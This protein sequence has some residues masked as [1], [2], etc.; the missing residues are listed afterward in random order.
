[1]KSVIIDD[2]SR[3]ILAGGEFKDVDTENSKL[4]VDQLVERYWW[5]CPLRALLKRI[6][7]GEANL[8]PSMINSLLMLPSSSRLDIM[9]AYMVLEIVE[10][11]K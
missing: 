2:A 1:M 8:S 11:I 4:V 3:M 6:E 9:T 7:L 10:A 5:I